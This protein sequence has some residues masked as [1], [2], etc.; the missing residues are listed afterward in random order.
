MNALLTDAD[1][2]TFLR[3]QAKGVR[4]LTSVCTGSPVLGAAGL[5]RGKRAATH[6][7]SMDFLK[8]FDAIPLDER[9]VVDGSLITGGGVTAGIDFA[10]RALPLKSPAR[11]SRGPSSLPSSMNQGR[12]SIAAI[13]AERIPFWSR[14]PSSARKR[15]KPKKGRGS[16]PQKSISVPWMGYSSGR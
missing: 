16:A 12:R 2:L 1:T 4:Y 8:A 10:L 11:K 9:V 15:S 3:N 6:W 13:R 5:L 7:M 14:R